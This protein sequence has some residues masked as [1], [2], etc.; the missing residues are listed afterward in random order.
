MRIMSVHLPV[1][2]TCY[3]VPKICENR[4]ARASLSGGMDNMGRGAGNSC[5]QA[6]RKCDLLR[7]DRQAFANLKHMLR[8]PRTRIACA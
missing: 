3:C 2:L 8:N 1:A 5:Y 4:L 7:F 6:P